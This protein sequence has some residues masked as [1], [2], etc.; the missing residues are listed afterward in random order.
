MLKREYPIIE[1]DSNSPNFIPAKKNIVNFSHLPSKC[2]LSFF[3]DSIADF[4]TEF[5]C[6][7]I[8]ELKLES[9][10]LPIYEYITDDNDIIAIMHC[11][12]SGPYAAGQIEKLTA[13]GCTTFVVCGGCGVLVPEKQC[14]EIFIPVSAVRDEGTSYHYIPPAREIHIDPAVRDIICNYLEENGI[15][16]Q[17]VKTWTT[18]AMYRETVDMI[19]LRRN[20]GCSIVEMECASYYA[21]ARYKQVKLGMVLYAGDD[22]SGRQ[23]NSRNWKNASDTRTL[24]LKLSIEICKKI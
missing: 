6:K 22:L 5:N 2:V 7:R 15:P 13:M 3:G 20:E 12:G 11:L 19:E 10:I 9:I 4:V 17:C 21:V 16:Y 1:F 18:D 8:G 24:L 14:G 23:W